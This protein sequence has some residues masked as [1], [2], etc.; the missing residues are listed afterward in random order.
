MLA[1]LGWRLQIRREAKP[2]AGA[3]VFASNH[4]SHLD[5]PMVAVAAVRPVRFLAVE[6]L[7]SE[8]WWLTVVLRVFGAIPLS[9]SRAPLGAARAALAHLRSGGSIGVFPEGGIQPGWGAVQPHPAA[10]WLCV[11]SN[12]PLVPVAVLGTEHAYGLG[13]SRLRRRAIT[14]RVGAAIRPED[15]V[16]KEDPQTAMMDAWSVAVERM[17]GS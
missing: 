12:V 13:A 15:F 8:H 17:L 10:A 2:P 9:R 6:G 4:L 3:V 1:R 5:I 7:W 14:V 16:G 11:R